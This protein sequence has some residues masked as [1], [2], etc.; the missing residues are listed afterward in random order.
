VITPL[1]SRSPSPVPAPSASSVLGRPPRSLSHS[2]DAISPRPS[3]RRR[4]NRDHADVPTAAPRSSLVLVKTA[5]ASIAPSGAYLA[6]E[7]HSEWA[8]VT[9]QDPAHRGHQIKDLNKALEFEIDR[10]KNSGLAA[11]AADLLTEHL[12][13][14]I[15]D[16]TGGEKRAE[17][18][19][20]SKLE[21]E[22]LLKSVVPE[23]APIK[24][25][26][27]QAYELLHAGERAESLDQA[28]EDSDCILNH[29]GDLL[30]HL[31]TSAINY[32]TLTDKGID[33]A[34][35][36]TYLDLVTETLPTS[37]D[38]KKV[39]LAYGA[40]MAK[41]AEHLD[42]DSFVL[43]F[44]KIDFVKHEQE[45]IIKDAVRQLKT[46]AED[47]LENH[48]DGHG[49]TAREFEAYCQDWRGHIPS[50][51]RTMHQR[52]NQGGAPNQG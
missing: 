18:V 19:L 31:T 21:F 52:S 28:P 49:Q 1:R 41:L 20:D 14:L 48:L 29:S 36:Q 32:Y 34:E 2:S 27:G 12:R 30:N 23:Y 43:D 51:L 5:Q 47:W 17:E 44:I 9:A 13:V 50:Y 8:S 4:L 46:A 40:S 15:E 35:S 24:T 7:Q 33:D 22:N 26:L 11:E 10:I 38:L 39:S 37:S 3:Q 16:L 25:R 6:R 42:K 45:M